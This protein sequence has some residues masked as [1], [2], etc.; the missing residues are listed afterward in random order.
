MPAVN[1]GE[2]QL[3]RAGRRA[4][5]ESQRDEPASHTDPN[6]SNP[7]RVDS[8]LKVNQQ[9]GLLSIML[10]PAM[11]FCAGNKSAVPADTCSLPVGSQRFFRRRARFPWHSQATFKDSY[12]RN[13]GGMPVWW[14]ADRLDLAAHRRPADSAV[15]ESVQVHSVPAQF[16]S[17]RP[18]F[19][20]AGVAVGLLT[21]GAFFAALAGPCAFAATIDIG[22]SQV[23]QVFGLMNI[24]GNLAAA[25]CPVIVGKL[26]QV[27]AN[28]NLIL[29]VCRCLFHWGGTV[30]YW[31]TLDRNEGLRR[32]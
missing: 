18:W 4:T 5:E 27:T 7:Y 22:G 21:L 20:E 25:A 1:P 19:V 32:T 2:L 3:I 24:V 15:A 8:S 9:N 12:C 17:W 28:W 30:G 13:T 26:F 11:L 29:A 16:L 14:N 23:P 10:S 6:N 31:S